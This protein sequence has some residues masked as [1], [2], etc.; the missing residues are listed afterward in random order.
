MVN[1]PIETSCPNFASGF[2]GFDFEGST[3]FISGCV[4]GYAIGGYAD[5]EYDV[6]L[7]DSDFDDLHPERRMGGIPKTAKVIIGKNVFIGSHVK[8][9]KGVTI[10]DNSIIANSSIVTKSIPDNVIAAGNPC[11]V[12]KTLDI[13]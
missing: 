3:E 10:G 5:T 1:G 12:I 4:S 7:V 11:K 8:I 2:T 9:L 6:T 13:N